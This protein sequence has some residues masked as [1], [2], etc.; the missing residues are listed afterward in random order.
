M[1]KINKEL[2]KLI[3]AHKAQQDSTLPRLE[4][5]I[6]NNRAISEAAKKLQAEKEAQN[7]S[8]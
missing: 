5:Q 2:Q 6:Q 4:K 3:D 1:A 8:Q 7:P